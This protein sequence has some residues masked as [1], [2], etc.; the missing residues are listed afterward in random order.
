MALPNSD[1]VDLTVPRQVDT[2]LSQVEAVRQ[3]QLDALP[4][5]NLDVVSAAYRGRVERILHDV[6]TAR[7]RL[8][9]GLYGICV[10]CVD[11]ISHE[12]LEL[13]PWATRCASCA[14]RDR[15]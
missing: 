8:A 3:H 9:T 13:R 15:I 1:E 10:S 6:R 2:Y 11:V 7:R 5:A 12:R 14:S 4:A